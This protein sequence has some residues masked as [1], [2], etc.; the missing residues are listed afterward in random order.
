M[1]QN[2]KQNTPVLTADEYLLGQAHTLYHRQEPAEPELRLFATYLM[3]VNMTIGDEFYVPTTYI[4]EAR[5][6]EGTAVYLTLSRDDIEEKQLTRIPQFIVDDRF[7][8][9][10]LAPADNSAATIPPQGQPIEDNIVP[11]PPNLQTNPKDKP[12]PP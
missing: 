5:R 8:E 10:G 1:K 2:L 3:V 9:E 11:L 12:N 7:E 6:E 4:D